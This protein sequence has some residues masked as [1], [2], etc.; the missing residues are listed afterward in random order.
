[1]TEEKF[2]CQD[3]VIG[4]LN[5]SETEINYSWDG[6]IIIDEAGTYKI[7]IHMIHRAWD[8]A[9]KIPDMDP[10]MA[11]MGLDLVTSTGPIEIEENHEAEALTQTFANMRLE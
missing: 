1:M 9:Q 5:Q 4:V 11:L 8:E 6:R 10:R 2:L 7:R 3:D